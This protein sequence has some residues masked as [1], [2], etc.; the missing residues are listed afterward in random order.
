M[1]PENFD[2]IIVSLSKQDEWYM[3]LL[4][5][6]RN[7]E[8]EFRQ[9]KAKLTEE[10]QELLDQYISTCEDM[11]YRQS[12]LAAQYFALHGAKVFEQK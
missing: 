1:V 10:E 5:Q 4:D 6:C 12:Q 9:I 8:P 2:D 11:L 3:E 7:L